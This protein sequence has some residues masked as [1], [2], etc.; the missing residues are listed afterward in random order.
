MRSKII[1]IKKPKQ[2]SPGVLK[3]ARQVCK[4]ADTVLLGAHFYGRLRVTLWF[5]G[6]GFPIK[7]LK[8]LEK[9]IFKK[10]KK[11]FFC[12]GNHRHWLLVTRASADL[13]PDNANYMAPSL[14]YLI[15]CLPKGQTHSIKTVLLHGLF[16]RSKHSTSY[17]PAPRTPIWPYCSYSSL[18]TPHASLINIER[19]QDAFT[20]SRTGH[21]P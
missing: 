8:V 14:T 17:L 3:A 21:N 13:S 11:I 5:C 6:S 18:L 7:P 20:T 2:A 1:I 16:P 10:N 4:T 15:I 12:C 9:F 19:E